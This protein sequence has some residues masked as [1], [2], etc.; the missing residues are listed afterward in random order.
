MVN[1]NVNT[2][3]IYNTM[4]FQTSFSI[5]NLANGQKKIP[6]GNFYQSV[7]NNLFH[8][9][10]YKLS[11]SINFSCEPIAETLPSGITTIL[12]EIAV[13]FK[14]WFVK[15]GSGSITKFLRKSP[16][17]LIFISKTC[18]SINCSLEKAIKLF[19]E[20]GLTNIK[21]LIK[22]IDIFSPNLP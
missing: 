14:L 7:S 20:R 1:K 5:S 18:F 3:L 12:S 16:V 8:A 22:T 2:T 17:I 10:L 4:I 9:A 13:F 11:L 21:I 15:N 6:S 19:T